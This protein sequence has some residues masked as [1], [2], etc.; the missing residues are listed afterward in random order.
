MKKSVAR[1]V[2]KAHGERVYV[3]ENPCVRGHTL[4][5]TSSGTCIEC[6]RMTE[7]ARVAKNREAYNARKA[8]ERMG[9][10]DKL[11]AKMRERRAA[12]SPEI[13]AA[14]LEKARIK[15]REW[16]ENNPQH[17]GAKVAKRAYKQRNPA[18]TR[19]DT[20]QRRA[21]KMHRTPEWLTTDDFWLIEQAYELAELRTRLF[22]FSWHVDHV[23]PLQ[24]RYVSGLH[25]PANLQVIPW[26][27]NVSKANKYLPA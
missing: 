25:V 22:G 6:R 9:H 19:A 14:R 23:L 24:G 7:R 21:A 27:D 26:I 5:S 15:Q 13:R 20:V 18:K 17:E 8:R 10:N 12:E 11:A 2:A 4:R 16:R 1:V 3:P